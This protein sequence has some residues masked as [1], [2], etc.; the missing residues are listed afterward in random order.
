MNDFGFEK[1]AAPPKRPRA[2]HPGRTRAEQRV[3]D[4]IGGGN[5]TPYMRQDLRM[6]MLED[7]LIVKLPDKIIPD[8]LGAIHVEQYDL[9]SWVHIAWCE[10]CSE[11]EDGDA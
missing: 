5:S 11:Q 3:I 4:A 1:P 6:K 8:R 10:W 7:G 9:P 2:K